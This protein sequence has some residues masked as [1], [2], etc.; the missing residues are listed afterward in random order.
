MRLSKIKLA[1][2]KSFVDPTTIP[3]P[4]NLIGIVGPNGCGK[5]NVIDAV[6]WVMGESS[7]KNLRGDSMA[8]VIFN[9]STTRKP[10]GQASI[11]LI[12][13]NSDGSL[14]G[15]YAQYNEISIKRVVNRDGQSSYFQNGTRCRRKDITDIFLGTGLG[16]RSY[17]IIEQ[18]MISRLIEAKPEDLR[19]FLE[20]AAGISKYKERRRETENRIKHTRENMDRLNDLRD[21][22]A[23]QLD[24]LNR[25]SK[26]AEKYKVLKEEERLLKAQLTAL[27]WQ[28]LDGQI[29]D[30]DSV[31][32]EKENQYQ[33]NVAE[34]RRLEAELEKQR[35]EHVEATEQFNDV[36][37]DFYGVGSEI[38][39]VEQSIQHSK[40]RRQQQQDDLKQ[41][42]HSLIESRAHL[43]ADQKKQAELTDF[44][45]ANQPMLDQSR[46]VEAESA[47]RLAQAEENMQQW[48]SQWEQFNVDAAVP[49]QQAEVERTT[50]NHIE[51]Q[52]MQNQQRLEKLQLEKQNLS[53]D[54]LQQ[55]IE[56]LVFEEQQKAEAME[57][58]Q[59][60]L[61]SK[62]ENITQTR[63]QLHQLGDQLNEQ[64]NQLQSLKGR[65]SSLEALQ[66]AALGK[67]QG[68]VLSW[69]EH[70]DLAE[71]SR[72]AQHIEVQ[73]GWE[74]AVETVLGHNLEAVCL[75]Q[76]DSISGSV[77]SLEQ[78][79]LS[80]I[81]KSGDNNVSHDHSGKGEALLQKIKAP[82][83]LS[84]L[85]GGVYCVAELS[86]AMAMR[87]S[88]ADYESV[89]TPDGLW[90]GKSWLR[91]LREQDE[92]AGVLQREQ[93]IKEAL[94]RQ[95]ELS[96]RVDT[97]EAQ[98]SEARD[99]LKMQESE[100]DGLQTESQQISREHSEVSARLSNRQARLEQLRE[101]A[102]KIE[103]E[104]SE[105]QQA[106]E[107]A[108]Q[109]SVQ[110][111]QR[112]NE[113]LGHMEELANRREQLSGEREQ[114]QAQLAQA[115]QQAREDREQAHTIALK[116][117]AARTEITSILQ[118]QERMDKQLEQL[119]S[120]QGELEQALA[121]SE[122]P[123]VD[124][125]QEL[126]ELL[127]KRVSVEA[128]LSDAR[129]VVEALDHA[130][131]ENSAQRHNVEQ[132]GQEIRGRL[133]QIK[134]EWQEI[135]VRRQ[136]LEETLQE[137]GFSIE[138]IFQEMPEGA[139]EEEW[140]QNLEK[141]TN[142]I[143]RLGPINLA[144]IDEYKQ[145]LERK[146]YLDAQHDDLTEALD[147]LENA[148]RKIDR[149][150]RE[151][152]K[153]TYERVNAGFKENFPRLFGG[154]HAYLELTGEDLLDTGVAVMA[155][156][157]GKRNS[158]IHL[159]SG[160][161][162]ALTA[163]ALVFSIFQLNP[164]PFC[165]LDEVD[166][167]L[168]DANVG[169]FCDMVKYMS[170]SVQFIFITH[171]KITM[172]LANQLNGVTM[173]EPGVSRLVAV[174]VDE[175]AEMAMA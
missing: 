166:A 146:E 23:K 47:A 48:Q 173:N 128:Q 139:N 97:L 7:A 52:M 57:V 68:I 83:N 168:D 151:R 106:N 145:Q 45:E 167:P 46:E 2:F 165:M 152:F 160:G 81:E 76:L 124:M 60:Q 102:E 72:L 89:I 39:R 122:Q 30:K 99:S 116:V 77:S 27:R 161:E 61:H 85:L 96:E 79:V 26:T 35:E 62:Q 121:E 130:M 5:S 37:A 71:A 111:R 33:A 38:S 91:V 36:Q 8:D 175:A 11:E 107:K 9:G 169:R 88:L 34:L 59:E 159:L 100:R 150:T 112:L 101:R 16:P 171:N 24:R 141:V 140:H 119:Q 123:L 31:I 110:S 4:S 64:R 92:K 17:S 129:K 155:R 149:E 10:V 143:S 103:G 28:N 19:V 42:E 144:A 142:R 32:K 22:L 78:G 43:D 13:D 75:D 113:A 157:P 93:E 163:V 54:E 12:F 41:V 90:L 135:K 136:T 127:G 66:Q 87:Q 6:R 162:K 134:L 70:N 148:I 56:T 20:E 40:E 74:R 138:T 82:W 18:G 29:N 125:G 170:E 15:E 131:R 44:L 117:E 63:D 73:S 65:L 109:D 120:R 67:Q 53:T 14:G 153:E 118:N 94:Q 80:F 25:Q 51:Q 114:H 154:G 95:D 137:S 84:G 98:I 115:R 55:S 172:E 105:I 108:E 164:A 86:Q 1:G 158:S 126:E 147:T 50:L 174:D 104:L 132:A 3:M 156:P 133:D 69:L 49:S 21:E 58:L